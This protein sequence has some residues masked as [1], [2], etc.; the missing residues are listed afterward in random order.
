M[1]MLSLDA[2]IMM[3]RNCW[4]ALAP[5]EQPPPIA[6]CRSVDIDFLSIHEFVFLPLQLHSDEKIT[7][8]KHVTASLESLLLA[9]RS[10]WTEV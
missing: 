10:S 8:D 9:H 5:T 4:C 2:V 7:S 3:A 6:T 1:I